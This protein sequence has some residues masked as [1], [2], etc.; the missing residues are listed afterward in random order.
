MA[1]T[2]AGGLVRHDPRNLR[3]NLTPPH[4]R[5]GV[6]YAADADLS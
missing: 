5:P 1:S 2:A 4:V 6:G 3:G